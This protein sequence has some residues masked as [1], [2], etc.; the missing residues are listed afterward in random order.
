[1]GIAYRSDVNT[2]LT[3]AVVHGKVTGTEF[4]EFAQG[5]RD[6]PN[7]HATTRSLTDAR[8]AVTPQVTA[9]EL[10]AFAD[11]YAQMRRADQTFKAAIVAGH[12]FELAGHYGELRTQR[13]ATTIA[14]ND[15]TTAC[16]WLGADLAAVQATITE[17]RTTLNDP[18]DDR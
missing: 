10:S 2:G 17:L 11:L 5:Q 8:T 3:V 1:M 16:T 6:D 13:R 9:S 15:L 12:D 14:F 18:S 4:H 7:W